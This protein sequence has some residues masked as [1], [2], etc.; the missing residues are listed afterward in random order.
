MLCLYPSAAKLPQLHASEKVF[1]RVVVVVVYDPN[2]KKAFMSRTHNLPC[3]RAR[4][5]AV[6]GRADT[7]FIVEPLLFP[8]LREFITQRL[9][10]N[11]A[12]HLLGPAQLSLS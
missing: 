1:D 11:C 4:D 12:V 6:I 10:E 3:I 9:E 7:I 8:R 2:A 5:L